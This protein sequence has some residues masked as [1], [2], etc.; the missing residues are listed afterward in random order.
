MPLL[1]PSSYSRRSAQSADAAA[2]DKN[3]Q[4]DLE[5]KPLKPLRT[6]PP[7]SICVCDM[8]LPLWTIYNPKTHN[9]PQEQRTCLVLCSPYSRRPR[10][11]SSWSP[12]SAG[13]L[14]AYVLLPF[15]KAYTVLLAPNF[16]QISIEPSRMAEAHRQP[17]ARHHQTP[18]D[19]R[20]RG[21][22]PS[23]QPLHPK[24]KNKEKGKRAPRPR[25]SDKLCRVIDGET[26]AQFP[27]LVL[28]KPP[29][30]RS[31]THWFRDVTENGHSLLGL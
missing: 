20:R 28:A 17:V 15:L 23:I 11:L 5:T 14:L 8:Y 30:V 2:L 6:R 26:K 24:P 3:N 27:D 1:L 21:K 12:K 19:R 29:Y 16:Y 10:R 9:E 4:K 31:V 7:P 18:T 22:P 25:L 13:S